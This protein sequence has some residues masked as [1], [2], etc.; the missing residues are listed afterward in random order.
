MPST[1]RAKLSGA[2][3][4]SKT[5]P[6]TGRSVQYLRSVPDDADASAFTG[7]GTARPEQMSRKPK[8]IL[9]L[10]ALGTAALAVAGGVAVLRPFDAS[11]AE[12]PALTAPLPSPAA[13]LAPAALE[14]ALRVPALQP[15][16]VVQ[17]NRDTLLPS[18]LV[19]AEQAASASDAAA[20][21]EPQ[22]A[23]LSATSITAAASAT[24]GISAPTSSPMAASPT[25]IAAASPV[26]AEAPPASP[27]MAA[28]AAPIAF[29]AK[30]ESA[31]PATTPSPDPSWRARGD[32]LFATGDLDQA[33]QFYELAADA[34]DS[35]AALQLG[36]TYDPAFL[37]RARIAGALGSAATA[38]HW[39]H[40]A[41][42]LGA[43]D[44]DILLKAVMAEASSTAPR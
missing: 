33:R 6:L 19:T 25:T 31:P 16:A 17:P 12:L 4:V 3:L 5:P 22:K 37:A 2:L 13:N 21:L 15:V 43:S 8:T 41:S 42:Q 32:A 30:S 28:R 35:R 40:R 24:A 34:G 26:P 18:P 39:Y 20:P 38:A 27:T 44:G 11:R 36:E 23:S 7:S 1:E 14:G 9:S 10:L 29:V